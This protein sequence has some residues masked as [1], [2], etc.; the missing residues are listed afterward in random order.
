MTILQSLVSRYD[1]L[2]A[3]GAVSVPGFAPSQISFTIV[4]DK[5]G[6]VVTIDDERRLEGRKYR[7][8]LVEAPSAPNDRRGEK[9]VSGTFWDPTD[10]A[11][12]IPR[13]DTSGVDAMKEKLLRKAIEK[14]G[15]FKA[16][17][18]AL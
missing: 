16:H 5:Q 6:N 11:L 14:H 4:L 3:E 13:L 18:R 8:R 15:A 7:P 10:Y 12:G 2:A 1:R 9:I 17:H